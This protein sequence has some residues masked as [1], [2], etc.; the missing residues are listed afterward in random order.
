[1]V[2]NIGISITYYKGLFVLATRKFKVKLTWLLETIKTNPFL[3]L[4]LLYILKQLKQQ[5]NLNGLAL[6]LTHFYIIMN[7]IP[8][9]K[10]S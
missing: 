6:N 4:P 1:M 2:T 7:P 10:C 5:W 8:K 9:L 3:F